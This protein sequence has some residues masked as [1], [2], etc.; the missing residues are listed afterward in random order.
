MTTANRRRYVRVKASDL[1]ADVAKG[2]LKLSWSV[3]NISTGGVY[4]TGG[5]PLPPGT[6]ML[7]TL[8]APWQN[9]VIKMEAEVMFALDD[10]SARARLVQA[11]MGLQFLNVSPDAASKIEALINALTSGA[12]LKASGIT[13]AEAAPSK[14][15]KDRRVS[16]HK[17]AADAL[18]V[19]GRSMAEDVKVKDI[20]L[21]GLFMET[22]RAFAVGTEL[23]IELTR[24]GTSTRLRV[25]GTVISVVAPREAR[26]RGVT[27]G[28]S[29]RF[30]EMSPALTEQLRQTL[31]TL[32]PGSQLGAGGEPI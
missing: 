32:A 3:D 27:A 31:A 15:R 20:S 8:S 24:A 29:V 26:M 28:M 16:I 14:R 22:D 11:G 12:R 5:S 18:S 30:A 2:S 21:G 9:E 6:T 1:R 19:D 10:L 17:L 13:R 25:R 23:I 4:V 7:L